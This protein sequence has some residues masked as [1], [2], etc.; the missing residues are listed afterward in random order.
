MIRG[1]FVQ[2]DDGTEQVVEGVGSDLS[3]CSQPSVVPIARELVIVV[4]AQKRNVTSV[5]DGEAVVHGARL[6][7]HDD[8]AAEDVE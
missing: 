3:L 6:S 7:W 1:K 5:V 4:G 2:V 8:S